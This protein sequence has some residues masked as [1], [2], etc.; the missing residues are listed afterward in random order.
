MFADGHGNGLHADIGRRFGKQ[1]PAVSLGHRRVRI[2]ARTLPLER[3]TARRL[4]AI[5]VAGLAAGDA[6]HVFELIERGF[7]PTP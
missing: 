4:L 7:Q 5:Q 3:L 2:G 6:G 1:R